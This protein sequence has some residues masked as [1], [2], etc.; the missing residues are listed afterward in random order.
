MLQFLLDDT[1]PG[2]SL[3]K[4][5]LRAGH[6]FYRWRVDTTTSTLSY[7]GYNSDSYHVKGVVAIRVVSDY[8]DYD[9]T[10][11]S[12]RCLLDTNMERSFTELGY[13]KLE[14]KDLGCYLE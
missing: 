2:Y 7:K 14:W 8:N 11:C 12:M 9:E 13:K 3:P 10:V 4:R 1:L 5:R 6:R